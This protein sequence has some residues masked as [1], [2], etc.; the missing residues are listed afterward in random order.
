[1]RSKTPTSVHTKSETSTSV[2]T[3]AKTPTPIPSKAKTPTPVPKKA[4]TP[5]PATPEPKNP[6]IKGRF[7]FICFHYFSFNSSLETT[8]KISIQSDLHKKVDSNI[9]LSIHG[10]NNQTKKLLLKD[11]KVSDKK[12]ECEFKTIDVGK[13]SN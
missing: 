11:S 1:M 4:E 7:I 3:K 2:H 13:V 8:Y 5:R 12:I 6:P 10:E 9:Y